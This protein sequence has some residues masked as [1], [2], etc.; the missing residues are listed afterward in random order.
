MNPTEIEIK[1]LLWT[2]E[3]ANL[4]ID[5]LTALWVN[6]QWFITPERQ[7]NHYFTWWN[8][9]DI[10]DRL[11]SR[12]PSQDQEALHHIC[13]YWHHHSVRTRNILPGDRTI[14]VIKSS[15]NHDSSTHSVSRLEFEYEFPDMNLEELDREM[16]DIGRE[17]LSKR[18]RIR[19]NYQVDDISICLDQNAGYGY[20]VEFETI[21]HG[22]E[23][24]TE[25]E[26]R[27]RV[28]MK[29]LDI[30]EI[31]QATLE[32]MFAYYNAHRKEYYG[33]NRIFSLTPDGQTIH[34]WFD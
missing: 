33:T 3:H 34:Y 22:D 1:C 25:A 21:I 27:L 10:Y 29:K 20:V 7:L 6:T 24:K 2:Q 12:M 8:V 28:F 26:D 4:F 17:F 9:L 14:L 16:L 32:K 23:S 13:T 30:Y 15:N 5:K 31:D 18:S 11:G 19:T